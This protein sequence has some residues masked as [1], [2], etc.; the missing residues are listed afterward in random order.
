MELNEI[1]SKALAGW[2]ELCRNDNSAEGMS[3][4]PGDWEMLGS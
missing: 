2:Q 4:A 1:H 3:E